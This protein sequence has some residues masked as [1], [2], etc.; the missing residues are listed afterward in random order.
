MPPVMAWYYLVDKQRNGI[1][2]TCIRAFYPAAIH[3]LHRQQSNLSP[4]NG[5]Q[6]DPPATGP[7][8]PAPAAD[9]TPTCYSSDGNGHG[10]HLERE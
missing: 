6:P 1:G 2:Q 3:S 5:G 4:L 7:T 8:T 10:L 9:T